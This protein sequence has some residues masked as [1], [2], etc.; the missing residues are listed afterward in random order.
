MGRSRYKILDERYP[1]LITSTVSGRLPLFAMQSIRQILVAGLN[2]LIYKRNISILAY[3]I[4]PDH[5][6]F[7]AQGTDLGKKISSFKSYSARRM[8]DLLKEEGDNQLLRKLNEAKLPTQKDREHQIWTEGF[9]PKQISNAAVMG[10]K[11]EYIHYNP[12]KA[13]LVERKSDWV[14]SS[15]GDYFGYS[16]CLVDVE[17]F[18]G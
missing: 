12:V 18:R 16:T 15:Y 2:F 11:I 10:Q 13:G 17:L 7:I 14:Y 6:H 1:Y 9:H 3:V 5:I 4:M 8:I